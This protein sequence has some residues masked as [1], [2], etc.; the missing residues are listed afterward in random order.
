MRP[1]VKLDEK[2]CS[3]AELMSTICFADMG[4][5][6]VWPLYCIQYLL[7]EAE[8]M[9]RAALETLKVCLF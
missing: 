9:L 7:E 2:G 6:N 4:C 1:E 5:H 3:G 8:L